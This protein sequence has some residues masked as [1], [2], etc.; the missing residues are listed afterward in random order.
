MHFAFGSWS[1][2]TRFHFIDF[3]VCGIGRASSCW[4]RNR[5]S[6]NRFMLVSF[7]WIGPSFFHYCCALT[8]E[9]MFFHDIVI[10][11]RGLDDQVML[12][13]FF[14][15]RFP[16][17]QVNKNQQGLFVCLNLLFC[18]VFWIDW[19][20]WPRTDGIVGTLSATISTQW[21]SNP[22]EENRAGVK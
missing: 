21:K 15:C 9:L 14:F 17:W 1:L 10:R 16:T 4:V 11:W 7:Y 20:G 8:N 18:L 2:V 3:P 6:F 19:N 12:G 5:F 13:C 22:R